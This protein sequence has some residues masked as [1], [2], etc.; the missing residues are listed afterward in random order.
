MESTTPTY[1]YDAPDGMGHSSRYAYQGMPWHHEYIW[2]ALPELVPASNIS[3]TISQ[4]GYLQIFLW[5][6]T[7]P[8]VTLKGIT[9]ISGSTS[10]SLTTYDLIYKGNLMKWYQFANTLKLRLAM[11]IVYADPANAKKYAEEA[12]AAGVLNN[13]DDNA[14]LQR[15]CL[16]MLRLLSNATNKPLAYVDPMN[17]GNSFSGTS[18]SPLSDIT[19]SWSESDNLNER[20]GN[21]SLRKM[22]MA[23]IP[24]DKRPGVESE[25]QPIPDNP[26]RKQT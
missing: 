4:P 8:I 18:A 7:A 13:N 21:G 19:I 15:H 5:N 12:V 1:A 17:S 23:P 6:W 11:R 14:L 9:N 20:L 24:M 22:D 2:P 26:D 25:E 16:E 3:I 10:Q